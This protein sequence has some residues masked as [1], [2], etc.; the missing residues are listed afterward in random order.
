MNH[1]LIKYIPFI[2]NLVKVFEKPL[3]NTKYFDIDCKKCRYFSKNSG[4]CIIFN[5]QS[6]EARKNEIWCGKQ[7]EFFREIK[8][9][10]R[11]QDK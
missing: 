3:T 7:A 10:R 2:K 6:F 1:F 11:I 8:I 4:V 5:R 9:Y